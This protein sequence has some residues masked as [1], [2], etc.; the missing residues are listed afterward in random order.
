MVSNLTI[1]LLWVRAASH[2]DLNTSCSV[3]L[4]VFNFHVASELSKGY[5]TFGDGLDFTLV[6]LA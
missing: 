3:G 6:V 1:K 4:D 2:A 5:Q